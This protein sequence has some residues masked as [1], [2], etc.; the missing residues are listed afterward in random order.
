MR[1]MDVPPFDGDNINVIIETPKGRRNTFSYDE[2]LDLFRLGAQ[3]PAGAIF[4]FDF[5]FVP[6]TRGEAFRHRLSKRFPIF[7]SRTTRRKGNISKCCLNALD[8]SELG[9]LSRRR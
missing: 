8:R 9:P 3:L 1:L 2:K 6:G 7:S 5:G 4:P